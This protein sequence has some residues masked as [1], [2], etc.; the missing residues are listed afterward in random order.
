LN[1]LTPFS[2]Y[3][4][5]PKKRHPFDIDDFSDVVYIRDPKFDNT[6]S[7]EFETFLPESQHLYDSN[8]LRILDKSFHHYKDLRF[9]DYHFEYCREKNIELIL[10]LDYVEQRILFQ[11]MYDNELYNLTNIWI[12]NKRKELE[13]ISQ[14]IS[15]SKFKYMLKW[16]GKQKELAELFI[17]LIEKGWIERIPDGELSK[18][19]E[20]I[21]QLFTLPKDKPDSTVSKSFYQIMKP[22]YDIKTK[23]MSYPKIYSKRYK[24][25]F[26][27]IEEITS[28][29]ADEKA[30]SK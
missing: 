5:K 20:S 22:D 8:F 28:L 26:N 18:A 14:P 23:D 12:T 7:D 24:K 29:V 16:N 11:L 1:I 27:N 21:T 6:A 10:N 13:S 19:C 9:L 3:K 17:E 4:G 25:K 2:I 15:N 30:K